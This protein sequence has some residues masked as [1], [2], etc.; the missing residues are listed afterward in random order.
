MGCRTQYDCRLSQSSKRTSAL[1]GALAI[2]KK[3]VARARKLRT[4]S[5]GDIAE[6][7][8]PF[9]NYPVE[10][11][12]HLLVYWLRRRWAEAPVG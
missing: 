3:H 9:R 10:P 4:L 6:E 12:N 11:M 7:I 2:T 8:K 5:H 1:T